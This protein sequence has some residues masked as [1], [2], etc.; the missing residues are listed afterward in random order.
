MKNV[1]IVSNNPG[2]VLYGAI[3]DAIDSHVILDSY[4]EIFTNTL[5]CAIQASKIHMLENIYHTEYL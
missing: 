4:N 3:V 5:Y 1:L 2:S